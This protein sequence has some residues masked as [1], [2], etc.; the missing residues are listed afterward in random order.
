MTYRIGVDGGGSKTECI[1]VDAAG[2]V[3]ARHTAAGCNPSLIGPDRAQAIL[4]G[5][6]DALLPSPRPPV[7]ALLLCMAGSP[8]FWRETAGKLEGFGRVATV[9]D[10]LPVLE[11]AVGDGL[12]LVLHAGT[13][14]FLAARSPNGTLH[15]AGGLGWRLG[16][17]GSGYDL[18]R[19]G[20]ASALLELQA[21]NETRGPSRRSPLVEALCR[22]CG[23]EDYASL[24]R[25]FYS[26]ADA[27]PLIVGF[28]PRVVELAGHGCESAANVVA[29][30]LAGFAP[31]METALRRWFP[32]TRADVP[33]TCGVSGPLLNQPACFNTLRAQIAGQ[34]WPVVPRPVT[35]APVEGVRRL[36]MKLA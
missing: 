19:R 20:I 27:H 9:P 22:H 18:G 7:A 2:A 10:S 25:M 16:D 5:G 12:G 6:L 3:V 24:S 35:E 14:S 11:L 8:A 13:G 30:S 33:L 32:A 4:A 15:Y 29:D 21:E 1:L 23:G 17:A 28:A 26:G 36:L 31:L 34:A